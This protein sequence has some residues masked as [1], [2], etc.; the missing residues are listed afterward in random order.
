MAGKDYDYLDNL[1]YDYG[2]S[3]KEMEGIERAITQARIEE[4]VKV[5]EQFN[6][7]DGKPFFD[8]DLYVWIWETRA[9]ELDPSLADS[10]DVTNPPSQSTPSRE[11]P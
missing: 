6:P 2:F 8:Q 1:K 4:L 3:D 5:S 11:Q 9:V 7:K 10:T